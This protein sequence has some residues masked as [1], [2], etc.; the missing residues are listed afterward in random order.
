MKFL[1]I[2]TS[3]EHLTVIASGDKLCVR[4]LDDCRLS[5]SVA[6]MDEVEKALFGADMTL[7]DVDVF[8]CSVGAG[9]FT[10]I[11]IGIATVKAFAYA[12]NKKVLPVT[13]FDILAYSIN[14]DKN[15]LVLIDAKHDNYYA[16]AFSADNKVLMPPSFISL[17]EIDRLKGE[18]Q[19]ISDT[20]IDGAVVIR[21]KSK[22]FLNAVN[23]KLQDASEDRECLVPLYVKKSQAEEEL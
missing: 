3:G 5:H 17:E 6:L 7:K 4:Y 11:R 13:S 9:S 20:E 10:G 1:A 8:A 22:G 18:Y 15:K 12:E 16:C 2:D 14:S 19:I 23:A 21:E